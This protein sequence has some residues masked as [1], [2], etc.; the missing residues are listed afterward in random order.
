M[1]LNTL[2]SVLNHEMNTN[3]GYNTL[4]SISLHEYIITR[5]LQR[6]Q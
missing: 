3:I 5:G 4:Q 2:D 6:A 1:P